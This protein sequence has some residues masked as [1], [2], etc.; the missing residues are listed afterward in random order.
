MSSK[1]T[2]FSRDMEIFESSG[3]QEETNYDDDQKS[4]S[5]EVLDNTLKSSFSVFKGKQ[6]KSSNVD[7]S[8][9]VSKP[10]GTAFGFHV[11]SQEYEVCLN[12]DR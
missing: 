1:L 5:V 2:G 7:F 11:E 12:Y 10:T 4:K 6:L 3:A 9:S 8:D